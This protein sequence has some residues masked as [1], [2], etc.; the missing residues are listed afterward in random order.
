MASSKSHETGFCFQL[1]EAAERKMREASR[2]RLFTESGKVRQKFAL[3]VMTYIG[4]TNTPSSM[5]SGDRH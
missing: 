3:I 2:G 4:H 5:P 1:D